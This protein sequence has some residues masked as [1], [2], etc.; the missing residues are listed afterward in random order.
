V[1]DE[2]DDATASIAAAHGATVIQAGTRPDGWKGKPWA[3]WQGASHAT[4]PLL[5][6]MDADTRLLPCG[7]RTMR[8]MFR[9]ADEAKALSVLPFHT[10]RE[11][12]EQ[13]AFSANAC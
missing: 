5:C 1:D 4:T 7:L 3:C 13:R 6:F 10:T 9:G 11:P 2:S 12:Y 8:S